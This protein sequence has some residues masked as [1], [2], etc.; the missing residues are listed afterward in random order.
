MSKP[1]RENSILTGGA[2]YWSR[3]VQRSCLERR[4]R[5]K[6]HEAQLVHVA[7]CRLGERAVVGKEGMEFCDTKL[8]FVFKQYLTVAKLRG[9]LR[10]ASLPCYGPD[11]AAAKESRRWNGYERKSLPEL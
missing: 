2:D 5:T 11:K 1:K 3:L 10:Q 8:R 9:N 6:S 7:R 4:T